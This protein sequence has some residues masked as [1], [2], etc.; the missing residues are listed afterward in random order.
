[1]PGAGVKV[2]KPC[3]AITHTDNKPK[4]G[5][6]LLWQA[7]NDRSGFVYFTGTLLYNYTDYWS[8]VIA[9]VPNPDEA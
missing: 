9:L 7:P 4:D 5:V 6:K 2:Y 3:N 1:M 8:D